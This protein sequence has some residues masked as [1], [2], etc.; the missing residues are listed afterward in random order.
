MSGL[1]LPL[2]DV[3]KFARDAQAEGKTVVTTNGS[4]DLFHEGHEF[5]LSE[6]KKLGDV[7]IVGVNSDA[8]VRGYKGPDRPIDPEQKRAENVARYADA[9]FIFDDADPREW[10]KMM[11]PNIHANAETYGE[12]CIEAPVLKEIGATLALIPVLKEL[13]STTEKLKHLRSQP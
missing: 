4:F 2:A 10:L 6:A 1:L 11:K 9:V 5:L 8:S 12:D 3:A 7:L 13:G